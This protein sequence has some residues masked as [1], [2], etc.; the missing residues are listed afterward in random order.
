MSDAVPLLALEGVS[1]TFTTGLFRPTQI[2][3]VRN[4]SL[5]I[6]RGET[7]G[8]VGESGSGKS[9]LARLALRLID[10][11]SGRITFAGQRIDALDERALRPLRRRMQ[12]VFQDPYA[13]LNPHHRVRTIV[14]EPLRVHGVVRSE[15]EAEPLVTELLG[16]VGLGR[17]A[18]DQLP[19][20]FS[21][22]QRQRIAIA[23][24]LA[25]SPEL[26]V[27][28]EPTS[29]LDVSIQAQVVGLLE[30]LQR[31]RGLTYLFISH[32]LPLVEH[33]ATRIAV[34]Y[35]GRVVEVGSRASVVLRPRHPYAR[36][37]LSAVPSVDPN[38]KRLRVLLP[39]ELPSASRAPSGCTFHP[40]C[41]RAQPGICDVREPTLESSAHAVACFFPLESS[42]DP[43]S[44]GS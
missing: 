43:S 42:L 20:A 29:A 6:A 24:A 1:K 33:L 21:G 15:Q 8:I 2:P 4:V 39:G 34:M 31:G 35:L 19:A 23:R 5:S 25:L 36:A 38:T 44:D 22:G 3:A 32:D 27:L 13:S 10:P 16:Q 40:R 7:L 30:E 14:S 28:D 26:L 17:D 37:L 11:T 41:P 12:V 9:T 18:L